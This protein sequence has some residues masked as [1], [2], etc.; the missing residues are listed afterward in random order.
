MSWAWGQPDFQLA[1]MG[2]TKGQA[3]APSPLSGLGLLCGASHW[4]H[5]W[6]GSKG[7]NS[8]SAPR[9]ESAVETPPV[10]GNTET[11]VWAGT[12][13]KWSPGPFLGLVNVESSEFISSG[14]VPPPIGLGPGKKINAGSLHLTVPNLPLLP[15]PSCSL[16]S[17]PL[18]SFGFSPS[19]TFTY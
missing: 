13:P 7:A 16:F 18:K 1:R 15:L 6:A 19:F 11:G 2:G 14:I 10:P 5:L 17:P 12:D 8:Q 4:G 9:P 3:P